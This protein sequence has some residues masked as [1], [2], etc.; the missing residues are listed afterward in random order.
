MLTIIMLFTFITFNIITNILRIP[1]LYARKYT[2][3][4]LSVEKRLMSELLVKG[5][6]QRIRSQELHGA[7]S[8]RNVALCLKS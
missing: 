3:H 1:Y 8:Q 2:R 7:H 4:M 5:N 6:L